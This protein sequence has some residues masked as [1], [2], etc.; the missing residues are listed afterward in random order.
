MTRLDEI[1]DHE[2][3]VID[4]TV[5]DVVIALSVPDESAALLNQYRFDARCEIV[6]HLVA[7][8]PFMTFEVP[9]GGPSSTLNAFGEYRKWDILAAG[10]EKAVLFK[11]L[12]NDH[13]Q[14]LD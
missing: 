4:W 6:C 9:L 10:I 7:P 3:S 8:G 13:A 11:Q 14:F 12:R 5:P 2:P 1:V